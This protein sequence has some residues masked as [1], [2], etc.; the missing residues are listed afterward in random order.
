MTSSSLQEKVQEMELKE[1]NSEAK[2][3]EFV[4]VIISQ[5]RLT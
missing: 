5:S 2:Q 4:I 1:R 3:A